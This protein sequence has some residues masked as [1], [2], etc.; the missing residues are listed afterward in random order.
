VGLPGK[1]EK[2]GEKEGVVSKVRHCRQCY[3]QGT[4]LLLSSLHTSLI[5]SE[6]GF[7]LP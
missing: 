2:G 5:D 3:H 1:W 7:A 6:V 4:I